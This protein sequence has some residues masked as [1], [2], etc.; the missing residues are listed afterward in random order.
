MGQCVVRC[1]GFADE[2]SVL[3][4]L[5]CYHVDLFSVANQWHIISFVSPSKAL[6]YCQKKGQTLTPACKWPESFCKIRSR[7]LIHAPLLMISFVLIAY[8][9]SCCRPSANGPHLIG[10]ALLFSASH[11]KNLLRNH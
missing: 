7:P 5:G 1:L 11:F 3:Q 10:N 9:F 4:P 8:D 2:I 6:L